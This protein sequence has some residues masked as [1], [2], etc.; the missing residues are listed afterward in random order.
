[1]TKK[2]LSGVVKDARRRLGMT[3]SDLAARIG[4]EASHIAYIENGRRRPS[5]TL[6]R[7]LA[8]TL[9]LDRRELLFLAHPEAKHL[10]GSL[11]GAAPAK[12]TDNAWRRFAS[13]RRALKRYGVTRAELRL[14]KQ[15]SLL[16]HV[17]S[18]T[19]FLFILNSI[20]QAATTDL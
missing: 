19:H 2:R 15:V 5:L 18:P 3:Q 16:E 11:A 1:M 13:N 9:M 7:R 12:R 6:L 20:R 4:V 17:S 14:L 8:D 10:V